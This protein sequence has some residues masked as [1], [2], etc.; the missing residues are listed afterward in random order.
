MR[1]RERNQERFLIMENELM[2]TRG[3]V[4]GAMG[5]IGEG[6]KEGTC[7]DEHWVLYGTVESL[8]CTP[9]TNSTCMLIN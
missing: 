3:E 9:E 8:H 6:I 2:I 5:E 1:E 4:G 7:C